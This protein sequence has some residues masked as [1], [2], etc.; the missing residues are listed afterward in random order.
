VVFTFVFKDESW[1]ETIRKIGDVSRSAGWLPVVVGV[2]MELIVVQ[3]NRLG[4]RI[5]RRRRALGLSSRQAAA[6]VGCS[7]STMWRIESGSQVPNPALLLR[8]ASGFGLDVRE[9]FDLS[10]IE[11]PGEL[12]E[13]RPYIRMKFRNLPPS[14]FA[15]IE[16][17]IEFL[18]TKHGVDP[19]GPVDGGDEL[20]EGSKRAAGR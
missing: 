3:E 7:Q 4:V 9:L 11:L 1:C 16:T 2:S 19:S 18:H 13:L 14:A 20:P 12:P 17:F 8:L 15:E 10:G 6:L 5:E